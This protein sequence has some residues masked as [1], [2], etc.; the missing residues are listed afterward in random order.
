MGLNVSEE[1][2][3]GYIKEYLE[4]PQDKVLSDDENLID[5]LG[6]DSLDS[7]ELVMFIE[8]K[9]GEEINDDS[10]DNIKTIGDLVKAIAKVVS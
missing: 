7:I 5:D 3:K 10:V 9:I 8:E 6:L 4:W 1:T 2:I